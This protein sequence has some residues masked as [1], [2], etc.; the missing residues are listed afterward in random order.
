MPSP[1]RKM[2][3]VT[4]D[5]GVW[6]C[7]TDPTRG[8][9]WA[10]CRNGEAPPNPTPV[11]PGP[12]DRAAEL[13]GVPL[14]RLGWRPSSCRLGDLSPD[15]SMLV[16]GIFVGFR[17]DTSKVV[18]RISPD[19]SCLTGYPTKDQNKWSYLRI[20]ASYHRSDRAP[21]QVCQ[22]TRSKNGF[23][24]DQPLPHRTL[25]TLSVAGIPILTS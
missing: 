10:S 22:N 12:F 7:E 2:V 4:G 15:P 3:F 24:E 16:W 9:R 21:P 19:S 13:P 14:A 8:G 1:P 18:F 5:V 25:A 6:P 11:S 23:T 17:R 20:L